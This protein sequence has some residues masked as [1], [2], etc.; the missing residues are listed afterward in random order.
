M[1]ATPTLPGSGPYGTLSTLASSD[2]QSS[3]LCASD[4]TQGAT[5]YEAEIVS[6][7]SGHH[8]ASLQVLWLAVPY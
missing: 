8:S 2:N 5:I 6:L 3:Y 7:D 1:D 4:A